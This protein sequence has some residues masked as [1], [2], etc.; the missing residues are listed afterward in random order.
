MTLLFDL[1]TSNRPYGFSAA[2]FIPRRRRRK[3]KRQ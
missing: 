3:R 2:K 1:A